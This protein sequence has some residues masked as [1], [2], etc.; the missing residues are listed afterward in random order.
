MKQLNWTREWKIKLNELKS[1]H[2]NFT[3]KKTATQIAPDINDTTVPCEVNTKCMYIDIKLLWNEHVNKKRE[4]DI[5]Y[6]QYYWLIGRSS[7]LTIYNKVLIYIK[8]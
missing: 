3:N 1:I 7:K 8:Y 6:K 2:I 4:L 5:K